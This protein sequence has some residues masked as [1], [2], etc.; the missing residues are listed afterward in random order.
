[1][2]RLFTRPGDIVKE[3]K[4]KKSIGNSI[5]VL[6]LAGVLFA[7][8]AVLGTTKLISFVPGNELL[9]GLGGMGLGIAAVSAFLMVFIGGLF[10]GWILKLAMSTLGTKGG[11]F[12]GLSSVAYPLMI[13]AVSNLGSVIVTYIPYIGGLL[14]FLITIILTVM[15]FALTY[16]LIKELFVTDMVTAFLGVLIVWAAAVAAGLYGS[17]AFGLGMIGKLPIIPAV[18]GV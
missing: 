1:M 16:R 12:E 17:A 9:T 2:L 7:I 3:I 8:A 4:K 13:L 10:I 15:A 14:A 5:G 18:P 6:A 11:Y